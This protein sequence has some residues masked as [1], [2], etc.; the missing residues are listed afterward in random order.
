MDT[1]FELLDLLDL[2]YPHKVYCNSVNRKEGVARLTIHRVA[3][4]LP[5]I[6]N[7]VDDFPTCNLL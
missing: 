1:C 5:T 7:A 4:N 3:A 6:P 2:F